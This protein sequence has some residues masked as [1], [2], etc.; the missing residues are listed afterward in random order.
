LKTAEGDDTVSAAMLL[1]NLARKGKGSLYLPVLFSSCFAPD[2]HC[3]AIAGL[4]G[5]REL[6]GLVRRHGDNVK[7][8]HLALGALRNLC[9]AGNNREKALEANAIEVLAP[10]LAHKNGHAI[11]AA[12][13]VLKVLVGGGEKYAQAL[14]NDL[15]A[16]PN[17]V[18]VCTPSETVVMD[19]SERI[20]MEAARIVAI[21]LSHGGDLRAR[22]VAG[23]GCVPLVRLATSQ[24]TV[25]QFEGARA[26]LKVA[27]S[28]DLR[29]AVVK[30]EALG[31]LVELA[32][33]QS[34]EAAIA[35][36]LALEKLTETDSIRVALKKDEQLFSRLTAIGSSAST[37]P[38]TQKLHEIVTKL[39]ARLNK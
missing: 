5:V 16:L 38:N 36:V 15:Q 23:G 4:G 14:L 27:E 39:L 29:E 20:V 22:V 11:Y 24:Y 28:E 8:L 19:G 31:P 18:K 26:L 21:V 6:L 17:L 30:A 3:L 33:Q 32:G 37:A 10:L 2:D 9:I 34:T 12:V 13:G 35:A 7:V 1:G 25:L